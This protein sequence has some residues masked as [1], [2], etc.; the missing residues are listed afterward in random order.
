MVLAYT[1][2]YPLTWAQREAKKNPSCEISASVKATQWLP[3][4]ISTKSQLEGK[5]SNFH[6]R[7]IPTVLIFQFHVPDSR[8]SIPHYSGPSIIPQLLTPFRT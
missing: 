3:Q 1:N 6:I 7:W 5:K 2:E 4:L 8:G